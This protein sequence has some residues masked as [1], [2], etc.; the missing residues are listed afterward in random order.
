MSGPVAKFS[1]DKSRIVPDSS[2]H[3]DAIR[4]LA[5]LTV[6]LSHSRMIFLKSGLRNALTGSAGGPALA[7][8]DGSI[9]QDHFHL[10]SLSGHQSIGRFAVIIFFVLS[11]Y[12]VGGSVL[13]D[14]RKNHFSWTGYLIQRMTRLWVVLAPALFLTLVLDS[15]GAHWFASPQ[16]IYHNP[17]SPF[18]AALGQRL[19]AAAFLGN[20]FFLQG[21]VVPTFGT[22]EPLW[23]LSYEFWF[24]LFFPLLLTAV[25]PAKSLGARLAS[26]VLFCALL[27]FSGWSIAAYFALWGCGVLAALLPSR[28]SARAVRFLL[29]VSILALSATMLAILKAPISRF[30]GDMLLGF[31]FTGVLWMICHLRGATV[32][33]FYRVLAQGS[34][35]ISYTLYLVHF[36][37]LLFLSAMVYPVWNLRGFSIASLTSLFAIDLIVLVAACGMYFCFE[38]NTG[39]VRSLLGSL[40]GR[41]P[42]EPPP[43]L[44]PVPG[45]EL[46]RS[47]LSGT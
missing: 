21:I 32:G 8:H 7:D 22:N 43:A 28:L 4:G 20:L 16:N 13:R 37:L 42:A 18:G 11:G 17:M 10:A 45:Q 25:L 27:V 2:V 23:S 26:G 5:S 47:S 35:R 33:R 38:R 34:S 1:A 12:F 39:R 29:P 3:L 15:G 40:A 44:S 36:P 14:K 19:T 9:F 6:F 41:P 30:A 46:S 31:V 24:Y